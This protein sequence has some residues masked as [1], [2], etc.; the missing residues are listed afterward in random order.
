[1]FLFFVVI[2]PAAAIVLRPPGEPYLLKKAAF[3][4][5]SGPEP[6]QGRVCDRDNDDGEGAEREC[7]VG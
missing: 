2:V 1:M 4:P 6:R 3:H 7:V 5:A